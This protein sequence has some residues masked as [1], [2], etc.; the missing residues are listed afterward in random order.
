MRLYDETTGGPAEI[1]IR[2]RMT[3]YV[4]GITPY[5]VSHLGHAFTFAHFDVLVRYLRYLGSEVVH[6]QNVTDV[7]DDI[8]R[9][10]K[11]RGIDWQDL[12][13]TE[14]AKFEACMRT[15]GIAPPTHEPRA[16]EFV[17][18]IIEEGAAL[19]A[20]GVTYDRAGT[21]YFRV[22][23]DPDFGK[24][25]RLPREEMLKL[26]AERGGRPDDPNKD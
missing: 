4:C 10:A 2:D 22:A 6:A 13:R 15:I 25:S 3:I 21:V 17:A 1:E 26:A 20:A 14:T 18:E 16:T 5:D 11:E 8:L 23:A 7:D 24:L 19:E 9:V 12:A